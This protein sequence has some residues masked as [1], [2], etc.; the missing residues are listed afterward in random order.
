[1]GKIPVEQPF[2]VRILFSSDEPRLRAGW[3][4]L[5]QAILFGMLSVCFTILLFIPL[6]LVGL[7]SSAGML[8]VELSELFAVTL[9]VFLARR[10][11]DKRSI[12]SMGLKMGYRALQDILAGIVITFVIMGLVFT[13]MVLLGWL[14]IKGF[15]WQGEMPVTILSNT[16]LIF[17]IFLFVGWNEELLCRG[18]QLQTISTGTNSFWGV[19]LSSIIFSLLHLFNPNATWISSAGIFLAGLFMAFGYLRTGQLWFPI[20]LHIGWNFFEGPVFG[21]PVSGT[22]FYKI[23]QTTISGPTLWTGGAFGPEAGLVIIPSLAFGMLLIFL[24]SK[25]RNKLS[26]IS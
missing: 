4:L 12:V 17:F 5:I 9:S 11:L 10:F 18:Y 15:I 19:V 3:R 2:L 24:Y 26:M 25:L 16:L 7:Q 13:T 6:K 1:M 23:T 21:F 22:N 14:K 8:L 20:G